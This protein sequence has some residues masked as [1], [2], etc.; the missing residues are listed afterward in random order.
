[1]SV[2]EAMIVL[3]TRDALPAE[4]Q[5]QYQR[6]DNKTSPTFRQYVGKLQ[7]KKLMRSVIIIN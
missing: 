3:S 5:S 7:N 4:P 6:T 1:M 2:V